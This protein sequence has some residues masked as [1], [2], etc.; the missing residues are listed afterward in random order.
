MGLQD[1]REYRERMNERILEAEN[2]ELFPVALACRAA[3]RSDEK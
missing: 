3:N 1:F 2:L